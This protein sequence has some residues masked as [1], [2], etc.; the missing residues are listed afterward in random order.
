MAT[1]LAL[2]IKLGAIAGAAYAAFGGLEKTMKRVATVTKDLR[3]RQKAL[4]DTLQRAMANRGPA[5]HIAHL[6]RQ[7]ERQKLMIE[8]LKR[9]TADLARVQSMQAANAAKRSQMRGQLMETA[10]VA[11]LAAKPLQVGIEFQASMS[12]V[13]ALTRLDKNSPEMAALTAQARELGASTSFTA[14]EAAQAQGFLAMAGFKTDAILKSMPSMLDLAR[15]GNI[16]LQRT[17]DIASNIQTAYGIDSSEM[18]RVSDVLTAAFTN[19]NVDL[20]M[21][22]QSMKYMGPVAKQFGMSLEESAAMAGLLG[23]AGIQADMAGTALRGIM[24]KLAGPTTKQAK[25]LKKLGIVTADAA[26]N[27]RPLP[28]IIQDLSKATDKMGSQKKVATI[29]GLF[30]QRAGPAMLAILDQQEK[31]QAAI[32]TTTN[33]AGVAAKTRATMDDNTLGDLKTLVSAWDNLNIELTNT[34]EGALRELFSSI[35]E[36]LRGLTRWVAENQELVG[37]LLHIAGVLIGFKAGILLAKYAVSLILSPL[38]S[39]YGVFTKLRAIF[40]LVQAVGMKAAFASM[41]NPVG[42]VVVAI[43][44]LIAAGY[45]LYRNWEDIKGGARALWEDIKAFFNSGIGNISAAIINWSPIGLFYQAFA[46][47]LSWFGIEL[48]GKFTEFGANIIQGIVNGI[49]A[50][51]GWLVEKIKAIAEMIPG[52]VRD[53]LGINS[54]STV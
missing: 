26:G 53:A 23:N 4:G 54:P 24:S 52:P 14:A 10:A 17:A 22:S 27:M 43:G 16:D 7:Y 15:A 44:L 49:E 13:Q 30:D 3:A 51:K 36:M 31:I 32:E 29:M 34:N 33:S 45:L 5:S 11:Y 19:A 6:T 20:D 38:L 2:T 21:L 28:E 39:L 25:I 40:V 50:A 8:R 46:G 41:L 12:K 47:V 37:S 1:E 35:T 42:L 18:T 9:S 48:P